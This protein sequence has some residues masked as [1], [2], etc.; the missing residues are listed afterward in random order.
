ML[1]LD[2]LPALIRQLL[3]LRAALAAGDEDAPEKDKGD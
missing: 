3:R 2:A 1:R